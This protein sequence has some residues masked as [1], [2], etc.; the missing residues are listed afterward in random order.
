MKAITDFKIDSDDLLKALKGFNSG[1]SDDIAEQV[2]AEQTSLP[3]TYVD[4][5]SLARRLGATVFMATLPA[6]IS[7]MIERDGGDKKIF[8]EDTDPLERKRFTCAHEIAH[9]I[10]HPDSIK[11][12]VMYRSAITGKLEKEANNLAADILMPRP[13]VAASIE[14]NMSVAE[15]AK[16]FK[17]SEMAARYRMDVCKSPAG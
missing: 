10:L 11:S 3:E 6:G 1:M 13:Y 15:V 8:I 12:N 7:G 2:V 5:G 17:V 9:L 14:C 16:L 4:V